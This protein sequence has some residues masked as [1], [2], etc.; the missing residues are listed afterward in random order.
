MKTMMESKKSTDLNNS[1]LI[2]QTKNIN[3]KYTK[4]ILR[5]INNLLWLYGY[6]Y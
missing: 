6:S 2:D 3:L 5:I 1:E 4:V